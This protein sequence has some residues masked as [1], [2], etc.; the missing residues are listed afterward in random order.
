LIS[1]RHWTP[2]LAILTNARS[3][4]QRSMIGYGELLVDN[5]RRASL[6]VRELPVLP[7]V[8]H[9]SF[10]ESEPMVCRTQVATDCFLRT[11]MDELV[12]G[13]QMVRRHSSCAA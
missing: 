10:N 4:D 11:R 9:T 6:A 1:D 2:D 3:A 5:A 7:V 12:L 13:T 8:L